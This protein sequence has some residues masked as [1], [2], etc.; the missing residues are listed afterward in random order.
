MYRTS[1]GLTYTPYGA[2]RPAGGALTAILL[3][4]AGGAWLISARSAM[5]DMRLGVLTGSSMPA[6][7]GHM[8]MPGSM[9]MS[10]GD[11]MVTWL[12]MMT[13]MMIPSVLPVV[14]RFDRWAC[15]TG[16]LG[17]AAVLFLTGYLLVW[18]AI[19]GIAYLVV[20]ALQGLQPTG[21]MTTLRVGALLL[22]VAGAYQLMWPKQECLHRCRSPRT[23]RQ[24]HGQARGRRHAARAGLGQGLYCLGSC[25]PLMLVLLL[26]GMMNL[27]WMGI[28]A[29]V[30]LVEKA[31]PRGEMVS[32]ILGWGLAGWGIILLA[33]PHTLPALGAA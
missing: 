30:I 23:A 7:S 16:Q 5:P 14:R 25:W 3:G 27:A 1:D 2:P 15:A 6:A 32:K 31:A 29:A 13:A 9:S 4:L 18:G 10:L 21:S 20:Q 8:A 26:I 11:F 12:V 19:G 24:W 28:V 22:V 17:G 33:A